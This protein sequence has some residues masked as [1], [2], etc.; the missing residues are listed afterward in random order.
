[1]GC[2]VGSN[3]AQEELAQYIPACSLHDKRFSRD[4][5]GKLADCF[6][7]AMCGG[8]RHVDDCCLD[9]L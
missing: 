3:T 8:V 5:L 9:R 7:N 1:M 6:A 4:V 2:T